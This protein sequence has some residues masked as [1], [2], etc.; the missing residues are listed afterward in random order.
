MSTKLHPIIRELFLLKSKRLNY[1]K[2]VKVE[3]HQDNIKSFEQLSFLKQLNVKC[4]SR[5]KSLMLNALEDEVIPF[6]LKL[7]SHCVVIAKNHL[8]FDYP[9]DLRLNAH[10]IQCENCLK[11]VLKLPHLHNID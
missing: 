7:S 3:V 1:L 9:K 4:D 8:I 11:K 5:E 2:F 10:L 6:P